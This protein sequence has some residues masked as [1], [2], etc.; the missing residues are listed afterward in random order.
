MSDWG[1][2]PFENDDGADF[3]AD[4]VERADFRT[5]EAAFVAVE[6][7][8]TPSLEQW[9]RAVAAAETLAAVLGNPGQGLPEEVKDFATRVRHLDP[10]EATS[11]ARRVIGDAL[12]Q[13]SVAHFYEDWVWQ[14][15]SAELTDLYDRLSTRAA[16]G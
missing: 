15:V 14:T 6:T 9:L 10:A 16:D 11:L 3:V 5:V 4:L 1:T 8:A 12:T 7:T 13:S 2:G